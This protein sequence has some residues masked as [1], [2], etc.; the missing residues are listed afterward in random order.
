MRQRG[1]RSSASL[2]ILPN[3]DDMPSRLTVP[4][5]LSDNE[6]RLFAELVRSCAANHFVKSDTVLLTSF[7]Q[8]TLMVR[9]AAVGMVGDLSQVGIFEKGVKL[10]AVLATRLRLSPQSRTDPKTTGR[11]A[12]A[13]WTGPQPWEEAE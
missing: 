10:Q 9:R 8:A 11:Q 7:V 3:V 1:R 4:S 13:H 12:A 5:H 2:A 6:R